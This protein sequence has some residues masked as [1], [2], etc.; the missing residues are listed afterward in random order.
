MKDTNVVLLSESQPVRIRW[1][2]YFERWLNA[3]EDGSH[4]YSCGDNGRMHVKE[5][6]N[7]AAI[8]INEVE[9]AENKMKYGKVLWS[10]L[11]PR[12]LEPRHARMP[13]LRSKAA[14]LPGSDRSNVVGESVYCPGWTLY[15]ETGSS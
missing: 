13:P 15:I 7:D 5:E 10:L 2:E 12:F 4:G 9:V 1:A 14:I 3:E 11:L 8:T 6:L